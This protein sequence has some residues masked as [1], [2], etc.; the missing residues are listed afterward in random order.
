MAKEIFLKNDSGVI[1]S[2]YVGFSWT[3]FFFGFFAPLLRGDFIWSLIMAIMGIGGVIIL[4][5]SIMGTDLFVSTAAGG[6]YSLDSLNLD[7]FDF[8][9][10]IIL[11]GVQLYFCFFYNKF[12]TQSLINRG[13]YPADNVSELLLKKYRIL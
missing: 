12:Y 5:H 3:V 4:N 2:S 8:I 1:K 11:L 7:L 10:I 13:F 6:Q 9:T